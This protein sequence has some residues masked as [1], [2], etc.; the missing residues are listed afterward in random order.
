MSQ[1]FNVVLS[2]L[3]VFSKDTTVDA[4]LWNYEDPSDQEIVKY[5]FNANKNESAKAVDG[6]SRRNCI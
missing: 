6:R 5:N 2:G 4:A 3:S 1:T